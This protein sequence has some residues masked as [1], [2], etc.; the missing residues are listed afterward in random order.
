MV[1]HSTKDAALELAH[2]QDGPQPR[3]YA[4]LGVAEGM[5]KQMT[6]MKRKAQPAGGTP[7]STRN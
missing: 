4:L 1:E 2:R 3:A 7:Q 5:L 6:E